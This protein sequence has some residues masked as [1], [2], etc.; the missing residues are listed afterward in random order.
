MHIKIVDFNKWVKI[1][2]SCLASPKNWE[3]IRKYILARDNY[4]CVYC[5]DKRGPFDVDHVMPRSRGGSDEEKNLVCAC[6]VCNMAKSNK[7]P[8]EWGYRVGNL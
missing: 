2:N 3:N 8:E 4:T 5:G 7:T 1:D 6:R